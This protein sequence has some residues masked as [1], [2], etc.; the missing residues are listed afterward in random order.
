MTDD[1]MTG[2]RMTGERM[3]GDGNRVFGSLQLYAR[4]LPAFFDE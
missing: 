3:T 2:E 1:R 4:Y